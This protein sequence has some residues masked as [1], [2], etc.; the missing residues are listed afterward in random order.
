MAL[1]SPFRT[2]RLDFRPNL[3]HGGERETQGVL[4]GGGDDL[5]QV[6]PGTVGAEFR[7]G[8]Q[9]HRAVQAEAAEAVADALLAFLVN[10]EA[11]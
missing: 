5:R 7:R 9:L 1:G 8:G 6:E 10:P 3:R 11:L 4:A 2:V